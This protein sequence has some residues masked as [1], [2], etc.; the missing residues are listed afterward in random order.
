MTTGTYTVYPC[1]GGNQVVSW[2]GSNDS[3]KKA[4]INPYNKTSVLQ[5]P[6]PPNTYVLTKG[7][8]IPVDISGTYIYGS[9]VRVKEIREDAL[10]D[11]NIGKV[12]DRLRGDINWNPAVT[13][14]EARES[15]TTITDVARRLARTLSFVKKG[16]VPAALETLLLGHE[17]NRQQESYIIDS[18]PGLRKRVKVV[19][20]INLVGSAVLDNWMLYRYGIRPMVY[21]MQAAGQSLAAQSQQTIRSKFV[22]TSNA[23]TVLRHADG[24][25][26]QGSYESVGQSLHVV[27]SNIPSTAD[28]F[29]LYDAASVAWELT[30]LSWMV[31]WVLPVG[32]YL[33]R[34]RILK[35]VSHYNWYTTTKRYKR[36][37][38]YVYESGPHPYIGVHP[39]RRIDF[40]FSRSAASSVPLQSLHQLKF[41]SWDT[42]VG[43]SWTSRAID[44][45]AVLKG[46]LS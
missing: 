20:G 36:V 23:S 33:E 3:L 9:A 37:Q 4:A 43:Q 12:S 46:R 44:T 27:V 26:L 32:T 40:S 11:I 30:T 24:A 28:A 19:D 15:L 10:F 21:D 41:K 8:L 18:L 42:L 17:T 34:E 5:C 14:G 45:I 6:A 39:A 38:N 2:N 31:D 29:G 16:N 22:V 7:T 35:S 13:I 25:T 1:N